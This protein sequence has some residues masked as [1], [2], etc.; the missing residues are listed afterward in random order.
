MNNWFF[1]NAKKAKWHRSASARR[2]SG[3][4]LYTSE[5]YGETAKSTCP[6]QSRAWLHHDNNNDDDIAADAKGAHWSGCTDENTKN[7]SK[8][9]SFRS[10]NRETAKGNVAQAAEQGATQQSKSGKELPSTTAKMSR[11]STG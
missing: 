7:E 10:E 1:I 5:D 11:T 3:A 8:E 2:Q 6:D 4:D 9:G